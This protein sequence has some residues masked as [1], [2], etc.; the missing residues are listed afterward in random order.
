[1]SIKEVELMNIAIVG[2]G[3][4]GGTLAKGWAKAGH[5]IYLGV[6][7]PSSEKV[8]ALCDTSP[9]IKAHTVSDAA[10]RGEVI[11]VA[12][13]PEGTKDIAQRLGDV[14]G[15]IIID[16]MN[17]VNTR[18]GEFA[19]TAEALRTWTGNPDVV[20]CFNCTGF[21]VMEDPVFGDIRADMFAAG[22]SERGK[23]VAR[24]LALDL[25]FAECYDLGGDDRIPLLESFAMLWIDLAL[26]QGQGR[27]IAFKLMK[28]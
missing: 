9:A 22:S 13:H 12:A 18:A 15:K 25:G 21:N 28:R 5:E 14:K 1:M 8:R 3:N 16:C 24:K 11:V 17:S 19:S 6:R 27:E 10:E 20:K 4:I 26:I 23:E 7:D 2:A